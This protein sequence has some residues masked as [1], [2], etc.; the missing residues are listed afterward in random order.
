[1]EQRNNILSP[2]ILAADFNRLGEQM[3]QAERAGAQFLHFDVMDGVFVPSISFGMP[4][5]QSIRKESSMFFDVHLM[6]TE[7]V[8]YVE[9]FARMGAD[10]IT[11]HYEACENVGET[12]ARIRSLGCK[13]GLSIKPATAVESVKPY[14]SDIDLLLIMSVEPGFGGQKLLPASYERLQEARAL[15]DASGRH[16]YLEVDGGIHLGNVREIV[17]SGADVIVAGSAVFRGNVE[18]N[19]RELLGKMN[20]CD[21]TL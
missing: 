13:V 14:L 16:I 10:L 15:I 9:E 18:E 1:M 8:R 7:P 17:E 20:A 4:V 11:V 6:I 12:L 3:Q 5:L 19:V 2:S 21:K